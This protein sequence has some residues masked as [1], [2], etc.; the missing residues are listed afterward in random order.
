MLGLAA[1]AVLAV[2]VVLHSLDAPWLKRRVQ[3]LARAAGVEVDYGA[4]RVGLLTGA[5]IDGLVV[6]SPAEIRAFAPELVRVGRVRAEW[7]LRSLFKHEGPPLRRLSV[8]DV[9]V[10][11]VVDEHGRTSFDAL[12][13]SP[14]TSPPAPA[15][16]LSRQA[17]QLE[18][19]LPFGDIDVDRVT[20]ALVRTEEGHVVE[21]TELRG[22]GLTV[23]AMPAGQTEPAGSA[24]PAGSAVKAS[25]VKMALGSSGKPLDLALT[26]QRDGAKAGEG[27][28]KLWLAIDATS[29]AV[30]AALDVRMIDQSFA[31]SVAADH[32]LH[33]EARARFDAAAGRTEITLDHTEAGDGAATVE[34]AIAIP[35]TG[36]PI[37]RHAQGDVD[38]ARLLAWVPAG[39]VP[40]TAE[41]ARIHFQAE[42]LA[43]PGGVAGRGAITLAGVRY[44]AGANRV[45]ADDVAIDFDGQQASDGAVTG[46]VGARFTRVALEGISPVV[47][48]D[49]HVELRVANVHVDAGDPLATRGDVALS[50]DV[51]SIDASTKTSRAVADGLALRAHTLLDGHARY[52]VEV[53]APMSRLRL[54]DHGRTLVDAKAHVDA[55]LHGVQIDVARPIASRGVAKLDVDLGDVQVGLDATKGADAL[56]Y[57]L[58]AT[59]KTLSAARPFLTPALASVAPWD[60]IGVAIQSTG[61]VEHLAGGNPA[62]DQKTELDL[63]APAF[64]TVAARSLS[65]KLHSKGTALRHDAEG[66]LRVQALTFAGA[67]ASDDHV[68]LTASI[69]REHA[70]P[71]LRFQ[72]ATDGRAG[73]NLTASAS[74]DPA[75]RAVTYAIDGHLDGLAKLAPFAARVHGL[76]GFDLAQLDVGLASKGDLL[77][78]VTG[79]G[80]DG[81]IQLAPHPTLTAAVVGKTD[82]HVAHFR[83]ER[84]DTEI[85]SPAIVW[86]VDM[87]ADGARR[88]V[89]S[90]LE[91]DSLHLAFGENEVDLAGIRDDSSVGV[92]GDLADPET[93]L[94]QHL[95]VRALRQDAL[96]QYPIGDLTFAL[97]AERD[98]E[99]IV[100]LAQM[101]LS[102]GTGGTTAAVTGNVE[103]GEGR[104]TLSVTTSLTQDLSRLTGAPATFRGK[105]NLAAEANITSPDLSLFR[106]HAALKGKDVTI[107]MPRAGIALETANGEVPI[108]VTLDV[109][110]NGVALRPDE[111]RSPYSML[112]FADQHPLL[113]RSGF[114][115]IARLKTPWVEIA[116][117]VGNLEIQQNVISLRQFEMGVRN[118][119]ITGQFGL[120]WDGA[121]STLELHVRA[122]GVQSSHGEPFDGNIAVVVSAGDRTVEGRAE[123]LRIGERHLLDLLDLQDPMHVDPAMNRI[124]TALT[125]GYP[126]RLRLVFDHGFASA[127]LE[128]GGIA[129]LISIGELRGIPM[130]PIVDKLLAP[131]LDS[132]D[133]KDAP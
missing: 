95:A 51:A 109:G 69:D 79:V 104:H 33:A 6:Q 80:R 85:V 124:R 31:P 2:Y 76:E 3:T 82:L 132:N 129:R 99:G 35:D 91:V 11:V 98:R 94:T 7:S 65:L 103:L 71:S 120:D 28:A 58:H 100:H 130:G 87:H 108:T 41:R 13:S 106:V 110:A 66:D 16:P 68:T 50:A 52:A 127:R 46:H 133:T 54:L 37:V 105:G 34:A 39:L 101:K 45:A 43:A 107:D 42:S 40:V 30:T 83:W 32:W 128:L 9:T 5:E 63:D 4:V 89:D 86:H 92:K 90:H 116:P 97:S 38:L 123:I 47:A 17:S 25:R 113:S 24:A 117:L 118:G 18:T 27:R 12:P 29:T 53:D 119:T 44:E 23:S 20:L 57:A 78:I 59:A 126:D 64:E 56:D 114:L 88:V 131:M 10:T 121:K 62:I 72:I 81:T 21:R 75:R 67:N 77:G 61:H 73:V 111:K 1:L 60:R 36:D 112:R 14:P 74:F 26:R 70:S 15:V 19:A 93:D 55:R 8:S 125:L 122:T 115:S 22:V 84:G 48:R 49:G 96:P 102:N